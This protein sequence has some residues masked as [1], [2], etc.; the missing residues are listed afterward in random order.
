[1]SDNDKCLWSARIEDDNGVLDWRAAC[2]IL[3]GIGMMGD[4][5]TSVNKRKHEM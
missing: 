1:M 4:D 2:M 5:V 3:L